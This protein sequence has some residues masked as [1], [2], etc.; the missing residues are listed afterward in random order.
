MAILHS[1]MI[2]GR[3]PDRSPFFDRFESATEL[4]NFI[5]RI[6]CRKLQPVQSGAKDILVLFALVG[7]IGLPTCGV[8]MYAVVLFNARCTSFGAVLLFVRSPY[9]Y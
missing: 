7:R 1:L 3:S 4:W 8:E 2:R 5:R 9:L 6:S